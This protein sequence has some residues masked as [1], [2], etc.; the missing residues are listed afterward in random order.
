MSLVIYINKANDHALPCYVIG[1]H[2][3]NIHYKQQTLLSMVPTDPINT[4]F[5]VQALQSLEY[6]NTS[7]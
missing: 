4:Y 6:D 2:A 1:S 5:G 3:V 7:H